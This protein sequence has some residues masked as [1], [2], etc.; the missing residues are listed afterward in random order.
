MARPTA[1][2]TLTR[3]LAWIDGHPLSTASEIAAACHIVVRHAQRLLRHGHTAGWLHYPAWRKDTGP[4]GHLPARLWRLGPGQDAPRPER[5]SAITVR[6]RRK[7]RLVD[8]FGRGLAHK[9]LISRRS[10]GAAVL[11]LE[12][13]LV[14]R[15]GK[16]RGRRVVG[17]DRG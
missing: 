3:V 16:P 9:I 5:D 2:A 12:G 15:R 8:Q 6:R 4:G 11:H 17:E 14:Y 10:G 13:E 7:A 1:D